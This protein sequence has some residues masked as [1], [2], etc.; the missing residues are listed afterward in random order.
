[1]LILNADDIEIIHLL[2]VKPYQR[3]ADLAATVN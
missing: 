1:L 3:F 2:Q